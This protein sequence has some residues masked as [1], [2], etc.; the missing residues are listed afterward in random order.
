MKELYTRKHKINKQLYL[1]H[2]ENTE[3]WQNL[4]PIIEE[5]VTLQLN[6]EASQHYNKLTKKIDHLSK[7]TIKGKE[8]ARNEHVLP[9]YT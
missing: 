2:L 4:W 5:K 3:T 1:S 8:N 9:T 6:K 7:Q